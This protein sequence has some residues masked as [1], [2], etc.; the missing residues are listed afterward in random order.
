MHFVSPI[1]AILIDADNLHEPAWLDAVRVQVR[2]HSGCQPLVRAFGS[3]ANLLRKEAVWRALGAELLPNLPLDKNTT[4]AA[5]IADAVELC[6]RDGIRFFA[7]ASG[8]A[9]FAPLAVRL[10]RLGCEVWCFADGSTLFKDPERYYTRVVRFE[11]LAERGRAA[12]AAPPDVVQMTRDAIDQAAST[13]VIAAPH[14]AAVKPPLA[15]RTVV[16]TAPKTGESPVHAA[17][18][19]NASVGCR[20]RTH[21]AAQA[22]V[23]PPVCAAHQPANAAQPAPAWPV[24]AALKACPQL[25]SGKAYP[26]AQAVPALRKQGVIGATERP[27][28]W[29]AKLGPQF[30]LEPVHQPDRLRYVNT[31]PNVTAR[32]ML[33]A[34]AA[35]EQI[36]GAHQPKTAQKPLP[37]ALYALRLAL[38]QCG[39][40]KLSVADVLLCVPELLDTTHAW[41]L[42]AV[43]GRLRAEGLLAPSHSAVKILGRFSRQIQVELKAQPAWV[44]Y[45][46]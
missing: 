3:A 16:G 34:V 8:D 17:D 25:A 36:Q 38:W 29:I 12:T 19:A 6:C 37:P 46:G 10:R 2:S 13:A 32:T 35:A 1:A 11:R 20:S 31:A 4:D 5:L 41:P 18:T 23:A 33:P 7:I 22:M 43:A 15:E 45:L 26:L 30:R 24:K 28:A 44:R 42:S 40:Q 14:T 9:D 21:S 27:A 39:Y